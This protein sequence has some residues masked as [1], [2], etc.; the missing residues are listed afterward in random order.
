MKKVHHIAKLVLLAAMSISPAVYAEAEMGTGFNQSFTA[1]LNGFWATTSTKIKVDSKDG[2]IGEE[3][4]F[5]D[6]LAFS[7]REVLP[8]LDLT[9]RFSPHHM[10]DFSY[11]NLERTASKTWEKDGITTGDILWS[12][13]AKLSGRFDSEVY[14]LSYGYSFINDGD[15]EFGMLLGLHITRFGLEIKGTGSLIAVDPSGNEIVV[16][17]EEERSYDSGFTAPLPVLGLFGNYGFNDDFRVRGWGQVF[18]LKYEDYDGT[19]INAAAMLEY[20]L[21]DHVGIG[22]GYAIFSY[23]LDAEND[24]FRGSFEYVF[25]GPTAFLTV[26]F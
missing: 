4:S 8:L 10:V 14:R 18:S 15:M 13:G 20:D 2:A 22:A 17:G 16:G 3:I 21:F 25:K 23:E 11:V 5:E 24:N 1:R 7:D 12:A 9:Y 6:D 19:L 26:T